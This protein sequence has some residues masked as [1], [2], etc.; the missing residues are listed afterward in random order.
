MHQQTTSKS[1]ASLLTIP[2]LCGLCLLLTCAPLMAET[3]GPLDPSNYQIREEETVQEKAGLDNPKAKQR[4]LEYVY[5]YKNRDH[6]MKEN[7]RHIGGIY[8]VSWAFY[9]LSQ[10]EVF[11]EE[12]SFDKYRDHFGKLV[13]D[14]DEPF[15]NWFVHPISGSQL[16]L[17]YRANGY[18]RINSLAMTFISSTLFEFTIEIYTEPASVQD[19]Y[20]T[21]II[22]SVLGVGLE[23]LS[24]YLLNTGNMAGRFFGHLIN[25][26]TLFW[27][28]EGKVKF[29]PDYRETKDGEKQT[30]A[31]LIFTF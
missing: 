15:W 22:G 13:F 3:E 14:K 26:S 1:S 23:N 12:G 7:L 24:M 25:P 8:L 20:Q 10:P 21:P 29:I 19:L 5:G 31:S 6:T 2:F 9:P 30:S 18:S 11:R 4:T 28:Y 17:Y 27:F 16:F